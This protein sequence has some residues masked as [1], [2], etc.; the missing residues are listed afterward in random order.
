MQLVTAMLWHYRVLKNRRDSGI[1]VASL[2][3]ALNPEL[4]AWD[5]ILSLVGEFLMPATITLV[6]ANLVVCHE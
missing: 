5:G 3:N 4:V 6:S 2:V 1:G